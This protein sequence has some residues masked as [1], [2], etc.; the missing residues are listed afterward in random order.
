MIYWIDYAFCAISAFF[1]SNFFTFALFGAIVYS[2]LRF[3]ISKLSNITIILYLLFVITLFVGGIVLCLLPSK[4][5]ILSDT[6][7]NSYYLGHVAFILLIAFLMSVGSDLLTLSKN[8][9]SKKNIK[10]HI[11]KEESKEKTK[12]KI[13]NKKVEKKQSKKTNKKVEK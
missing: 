10:K 2:L 5:D 9:D 8:S 12:K 7:V 13:I 3:V 6:V 1:F 11:K 4:E